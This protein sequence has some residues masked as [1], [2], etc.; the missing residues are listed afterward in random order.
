[1][2]TIA[3]FVVSLCFSTA[4][5]G[6]SQDKGSSFATDTPSEEPT[7]S[8]TDSGSEPESSGSGE[9]EGSGSG[10]GEGEGQGHDCEGA[11]CL[12]CAVDEGLYCGCS[13]SSC[14]EGASCVA[15][16]TDEATKL[17]TLECNADTDCPIANICCFP[18]A[19]CI[20]FSDGGKRCAFPCAE[21]ADCPTAM[22]CD[23]TQDPFICVDGSELDGYES[24]QR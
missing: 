17:C 5:R 6:E 20:A 24:S 22:V 23:R 4:C 12:Q 19:I 8:A 3:I 18:D 10:E 13:S 1:M 16:R 15:A 7:A 9:G 21:T 11:E 14:F 2:R